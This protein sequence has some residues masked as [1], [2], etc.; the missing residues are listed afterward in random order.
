[1]IQYN[2]PSKGILQQYDFTLNQSVF[3]AAGSFIIPV[4]NAVIIMLIYKY[5]DY[6]EIIFYF[7]KFN[8][9]NILI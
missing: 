5:V 8:S 7:C 9:K 1:M 4:T 3:L 6:L 2:T